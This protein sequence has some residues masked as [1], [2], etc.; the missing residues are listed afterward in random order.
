MEGSRATA[1]LREVAEAVETS[2]KRVFETVI[3]VVQPAM[4][5]NPREIQRAVAK[6]LNLPPSV[7]APLDAE[8]EDD[9]FKGKEFSSRYLLWQ[10]ADEIYQAVRDRSVLLVLCNNLADAEL[11]QPK[12]WPV[13][14]IRRGSPNAVLWTS[15]MNISREA[16]PANADLILRIEPPDEE[17]AV[18]LVYKE[19]VEIARYIDESSGGSLQTTR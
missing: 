2:E 8:D 10:V 1:L 16:A 13:S 9:D 18:Y 17:A 19:A 3:K 11:T 5:K 6:Q 12:Q 15:G 4:F 7:T 14:I